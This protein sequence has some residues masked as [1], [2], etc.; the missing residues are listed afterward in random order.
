MSDAGGW[1]SSSSAQEDQDDDQSDNGRT[2]D[3]GESER[4]REREEETVQ[5]PRTGGLK[6]KLNVRPAAAAS[7][8]GDEGMPQRKRMRMDESA[9]STPA[10]PAT[11][12]SKNGTGTGLKLKLNVRPVAASP[13][14]HDPAGDS[15]PA[16]SRSIKL[17]LGS[18]SA[19]MTSPHT[20]VATPMAGA[21]T[22][23]KSKKAPTLASPYP[24]PGGSPGG[25][26]S[27]A[28]PAKR[29]HKKKRPVHPLASEVR[30]DQDVPH[31]PVGEQASARQ[32]SRTPGPAAARDPSAAPASAIP[33]YLQPA[34]HAP[35]SPGTDSAP[36]T[37]SRSPSSPA[38]KLEDED[39]DPISRMYESVAPVEDGAVQT[40]Q[41]DTPQ[42]VHWN[43][44]G[45]K[46]RP[47]LRIKRPLREI[48]KRILVDLRRKDQVGP[49]AE[50]LRARSLTR[51]APAVWVVHEPGLGAGLPGVHGCHRRTRSGDGPEH[52]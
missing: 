40:P 17:K 25:S 24:S 44:K 45:Q 9:P 27:P 32:P 13:A 34:S 21:K 43:T 23:S 6:L 18:L 47:Y 41:P 14:A 51:W 36:A 50:L 26:P 8:G 52:Y 2:Q 5:Q 31:G 29:S 19:P 48:V 7:A 22:T 12:A 37:P 16:P 35:D 1:S 3:A 30:V 39:S 11:A 42:E 10:A 20:P 49:A 15:T 38:V 33:A 46:G 4:E 28:G